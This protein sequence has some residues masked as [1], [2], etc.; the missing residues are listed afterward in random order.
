MANPASRQELVDYAKRQLGYPVLEINLAD[1][2]I[3]DLM[4]DAIQMYQ[5]RHMD[6]VELMY[7][8][9]K[10]T[11][12]FIDSIQARGASKSTGI[13]TSTGTA[14]ITGIGTTTFNFEETQNFLQIPDAVI[15]VERVWKL[16]NRAI[17][18]NMFS[19]NYQLFLNEIYWFTS[20]ELL[21]YTMTKRYLEDIDFILHPDKQIR[22]NRRQNRLYL[23][24][25]HSSLRADDYLIIQCYRV[26]N[27]NEFT[28]V[29]NDP[30]LKKYFTLLMKKQWGQNLIKF[31]GVKLPGG[32]ELN[33]REIYE[34]AVRDLEKL[35]ERMTYDYELPPLDLIG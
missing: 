9:F 7:L 6:G 15:G 18:T 23:D 5:N 32:V 4:D 29:Y 30:F 10:I 22:F 26:L 2:Q 1:E 16:D 31:R 34:D 17:S 28:K 19:V 14:N 3:E 11:Q 33:G 35:E 13:T 27:P 24:V 25:D 21:N 20:T 12:N 8:K